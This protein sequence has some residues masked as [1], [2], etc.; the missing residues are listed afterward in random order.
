MNKETP[1]QRMREMLTERGID[2]RYGPA[3]LIESTIVNFKGVEIQFSGLSYGVYCNSIL[4]PEKMVEM[5][6]DETCKMMP[7][8]DYRIDNDSAGVF[9]EC[10]EC[11]YQIYMDN[12]ESEFPIRY[13]PDC[14]RKI[15]ND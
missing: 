9:F 10:S 4:T 12:I 2:W 14:G 1:M 3:G 5:M 11:H 7:I 6:M 15:I 13:C 8:E